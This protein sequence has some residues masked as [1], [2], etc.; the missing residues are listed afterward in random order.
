MRTSKVAKGI[1]KERAVELSRKSWSSPNSRNCSSRIE[2]I[3]R[4]AINR[5]SYELCCEEID[6]KISIFLRRGERIRYIERNPDTT[7]G[8]GWGISKRYSVVFEAS[9]KIMNTLHEEFPREQE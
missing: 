1:M 9:K 3:C 6:G 7:I 2:N 4:S 8:D 5:L